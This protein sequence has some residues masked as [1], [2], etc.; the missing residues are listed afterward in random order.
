MAIAANTTD[1]VRLTR[2]T[3]STGFTLIELMLV[4]AIVA[5][6]AA[7]GIPRLYGAVESARIARA[8]SDIRA[9]EIE[10]TPYDSPG[11]LPASLAA[12]GRGTLLD[13]WGHP[14][15]Y[16]PFP[17]GKGP[18]AGSRK[19]RFLVPINS[20]YDLY[21]MGPDGVTAAPLT[22]KAGRDDVVRANDGSFI[23]PASRY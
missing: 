17:A 9:I 12:I 3:R 15:K 8:I 21:S 16:L 6:L 18:P 11:K 1:G 20:T 22:S 7:M 19:D 23:G 10:L 13:P 2:R 5:T 14:Y 4:L